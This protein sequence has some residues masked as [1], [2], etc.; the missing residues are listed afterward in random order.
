MQRPLRNGPTKREWSML[1]V[2]ISEAARAIGV[3]K[4]VLSRY[5]AT[6]PEL[7]HAADGPPKV[8]I[9]EIRVHRDLTINQAKSGNHAG[10]IFGVEEDDAGVLF[11]ARMRKGTRA[12]AL[13]TKDELQ[14]KKLRLDVDERMGLICGRAEVEDGAQETGRVLVEMLANRNF[15]L[16][17]RL[18]G[19]TDPR[20]IF[21]ALN[22]ADDELLTSLDHVAATRLARSDTA[23][24][25]NA[26]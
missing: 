10:R 13:T 19:M 6:N 7:N 2:G 18:A 21:A 8:D 24:S 3:H 4:S 11:S 25:V 9:D 5:V 12:E 23:A 1:L 16:A 26:A 17:D 22:A 14:A 15:D 20:E